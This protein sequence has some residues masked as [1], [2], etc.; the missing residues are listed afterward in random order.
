MNMHTALYGDYLEVMVPK[1]PM[2]EM[3]NA[4][5]GIG[6][7][8]KQKG[9]VTT[10]KKPHVVKAKS[11]AEIGALVSST[12]DVNNTTVSLI[13]DVTLEDVKT[14]SNDQGGPMKITVSDIT[15][16]MQEKAVKFLLGHE[17]TKP[18]A[19]QLA[20]ALVNSMVQTIVVSVNGVF[21]DDNA[22]QYD[23]GY[24]KT[25]LDFSEQVKESCE[26]SGTDFDEFNG[27]MNQLTDELGEYFGA[28]L[29]AKLAETI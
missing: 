23:G 10:F 8:A 1:N 29:R 12:E 22:D 28:Q 9:L 3:V 20:G 16:A 14:S 27:Q 2:K 25:L 7:E 11:L 19:I 6:R 17:E 24:N 18:I 5:I 4:M 26:Q 13:S 15:L 21:D